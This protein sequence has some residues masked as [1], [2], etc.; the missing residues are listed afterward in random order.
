MTFVK[1]LLDFIEKSPT[2]FHAVENICSELEA[3]GRTRLTEGEKWAW[4]P[5]AGIL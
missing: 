1:P 5:A 3:S 2:A 4:S